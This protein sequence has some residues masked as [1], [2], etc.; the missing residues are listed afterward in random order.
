M[1]PHEQASLRWMD[2]HPA[3]GEQGHL[4]ATPGSAG[5]EVSLPGWTPSTGT[6]FLPGT[7]P[8]WWPWPRVSP[9]SQRPGAP[10]S[11]M[12]LCTQAPGDQTTGQLPST[13]NR[14]H[15]TT[16]WK[17]CGLGL[18]RHL[19]PR[20]GVG[21][22]GMVCVCVSACAPPRPNQLQAEPADPQPDPTLPGP[23]Q[24]LVQSIF[25]SL[26]EV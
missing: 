20:F 2:Q 13:S 1:C 24:S 9:S 17:C 14:F 25:F 3:P 10:A 6:R 26:T 12:V 22:E 11:P 4:L 21:G 15:G 23:L 8:S 18:G 16:A 19:C 5:E 7:L